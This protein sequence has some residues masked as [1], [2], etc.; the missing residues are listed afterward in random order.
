MLINKFLNGKNSNVISTLPINDIL[1]IIKEGDSNLQ[2]IQ[3]LRSIGKSNSLFDN[4]KI[5][6]L[7]TF[8]FN[9]NFNQKANNQSIIRPT[10]L[11]YIDVD[12]S[13]TIINNQYVFA[14]WKSI[15]ETGFGILVKVDGLTLNNFSETYL[16]VSKLLGITTDIGAKKATQQT[17][18]SY[19][20]NL[21]YN[22]ESL[23]FTVSKKVSFVA[24]KERREECILTNDT[25]FNKDSEKLRF[26]NTDEYFNDDTPY[27][28]FTGAK[29]K[30]CSPFI[31][32]SIEGGNRN[33][34][35]FFILSQYALL[36]ESK[37]EP[38]LRACANVIN[39]HT[40]PKLVEG[41]I[42]GIIESVIKKRA[43]ATLSAHLNKERRL[44]FN[45][46]V[47]M[48]R[49]EKQRIVC[50]EIGKIK[51]S[52]T[53]NKIYQI[54]ENWDFKTDGKITQNKVADKSGKNVITIKRYWK[55]FKDY[56]SDLN[57]KPIDLSAGNAVD[58]RDDNEEIRI[59]TACIEAESEYS[60]TSF[61]IK[62]NQQVFIK[63]VWLKDWEKIKLMR[64]FMNTLA[65]NYTQ[66]TFDYELNNQIEYMASKH[67]FLELA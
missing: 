66:G 48:D 46:N 16:E 52:Q 32:K 58:E 17:V 36:N 25:F 55:S 1:T 44:L 64:G 3:A 40:F 26:D 49:K 63:N 50:E 2:T 34:T 8:R 23:T 57:A 51:R 19:D 59:E 9:F 13:D 47:K 12:G 7:P 31:P 38:F 20:P 42:K 62:N 67:K 22:E 28:V 10:G 15:S 45:P 11:I 39:Q 14:S 30:I 4:I 41:E 60:N 53:E 6:K 5:S 21:Y 54:L 29:E 43:E 35:M 56:A 37:G 65:C 24:I 18:L 33:S 27:I 61:R